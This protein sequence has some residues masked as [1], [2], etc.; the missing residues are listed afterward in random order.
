MTRKKEQELDKFYTADSCVLKCLQEFEKHVKLSEEDIIIEPSAGDGA[1]SDK[2]IEKYKEN[3]IVSYDIKP[4]KKYI[5]EQD[6]LTLDVEE[7]KDK[8]VHIIGN[9]PFGRQS[10]LAKQFIK[11]CCKFSKTISFIL[12]KSFKK[13][14]FIKTFPLNFH[15]ILSVD[16]DT[17]SFLV[18]DEEYD[19]PCVFQIWEKRDEKRSVK[20]KVEPVNFHYVK[21]DENPDIS[22]RR[23]GVYAGKVYKEIENKSSESHY[24]IKFDEDHDIDSLIEKFEETVVFE[25]DNTVGPRSIS[26]NEL[27]E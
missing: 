8:S 27:N 23:V 22:F 17:K 13:E 6:F 20:D 19:V 1:F 9:P 7:Y 11:K 18:N 15:Q 12:P 14:I 24:F 5:I 21:K 4:G 16:L 2:L 26:K 10:K 25:K 3:T